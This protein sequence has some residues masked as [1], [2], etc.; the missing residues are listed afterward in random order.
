LGWAVLPIGLVQGL[1]VVVMT[2][3]RLE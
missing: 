2:Q 1:D 3:G